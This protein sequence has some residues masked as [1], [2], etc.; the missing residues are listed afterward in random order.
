MDTWKIIVLAYFGVMSIVGFISMGVDKRKA[1]NHSWRTP[2]AP[3]FLIALIG[4]SL[5]SVIGLW[6]FRHK[7][8]HWYF[9]V[10]MPLILI[11]HIALIVWLMTLK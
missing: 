2:E 6:T 4:G 11:A 10:F 9:V 5:G 7:T 3:L 8:K 1:K